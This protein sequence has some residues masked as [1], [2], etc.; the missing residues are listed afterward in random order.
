MHSD[1]EEIVL[2]ACDGGIRTLKEE[3]CFGVENQEHIRRRI[4]RLLVRWELHLT[5]DGL[6]IIPHDAIS[7]DK[8]E[9]SCRRAAA[10]DDFDACV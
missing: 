10:K 8:R 2:I 7:I 6:R 4:L 9:G 5:Y 1:G 3:I